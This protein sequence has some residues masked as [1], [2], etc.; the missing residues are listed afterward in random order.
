VE[1][2]QRRGSYKKLLYRLYSLLQEYDLWEQVWLSS[3]DIRFLWQWRK[4]ND[5][6]RCAYLFEKWNFYTRRLCE[7]KFVD[8][9]HPGITLFPKIAEMSKLNKPLCFWTINQENDILTLS[10][11]PVFALITDNVPLALK[12][13][14]NR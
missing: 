6:I 14:A 2:K 1:I 9:L 13:L 10:S 5:W 8:F 11:Q 4:F 3:F 7:Q 12:I